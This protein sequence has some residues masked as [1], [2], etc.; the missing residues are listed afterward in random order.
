MIWLNFAIDIGFATMVRYFIFNSS[1]W[2][3]L[4]GLK[5]KKTK[6]KLLVCMLLICVLNLQ[7]SIAFTNEIRMR[8]I[9][10]KISLH[11]MFKNLKDKTDRISYIIFNDI[12]KVLLNLHMENIRLK[13]EINM[14]NNFKSENDELRKFLA[15]KSSVTNKI[16]VAKIIDVFSNDYNKSCV[17][18][19]GIS[20]GVDV[21]DVA[22]TD[23]GL[24]GRI[25][26]VYE[27]WS[28]VLF[29]T[30]TNSSI[31]VKI[32]KSRINAII[33]GDNSDILRIS[34][35]H[36][37]ISIN[38]D[39]IV[40]TSGY[41]KVFCENI[42][43]GRVIEKNGTFVVIPYVNFNALTYISVVKKN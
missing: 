25:S 27:K 37:D 6:T 43:V 8:L 20:D 11:Y 41:G 4:R 24:V 30:D 33:S 15:M 5:K 13:T 1:S 3:V 2:N 32:G 29:I 7:S 23:V 17:L 14:L 39:D 31:P 16:I 19:V 10:L 40:E 36:E 22:M 28:R 21:G 18:D 26:E 38:H 42:P 9:Q 12:D 35:K 34:V